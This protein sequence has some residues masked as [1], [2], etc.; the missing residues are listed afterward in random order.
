MSLTKVQTNMTNKTSDAL[1][2]EHQTAQQAWPIA[3]NIYGDLDSFVVAAGIYDV[4]IIAQ[5]V[6]NGATTTGE[7]RI[8]L[9]ETSGNS[10]PLIGGINEV[11]IE[12]R[13][14]SGSKDL[15]NKN[16]L[17]LVVASETTFYLKGLAQTSVTNLEYESIVTFR[18][19]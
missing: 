13:T 15:A 16:I 2:V 17:N 4:N 5:I 11:A 10:A 1:Y 14:A 3:V 12:K 19:I 8:G 9:G 6:S 18:P 7:I